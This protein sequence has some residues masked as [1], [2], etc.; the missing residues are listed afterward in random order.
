MKPATKKTLIIVAAVAVIAIIAWMVWR[1]VRRNNTGMIVD[2]VAKKLEMAD[3][4]KQQLSDKVSYLNNS[5]SEKPALLEE[6]KEGAK[7]RNLTLSQYIVVAA[8]GLAFSSDRSDE[9][10]LV[11]SKM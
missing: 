5:L 6:Y 9:I 11:I 4:E 2:Y 3:V 8:A 1:R 7:I 10:M